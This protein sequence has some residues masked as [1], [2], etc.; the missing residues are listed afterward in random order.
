M[1]TRTLIAGA[2]G[3]ILAAGTVIAILVATSGPSYPHSWC[4]PVLAQF[5]AHESQSAFDA[6]MTGLENQGAPVGSLISD[7]DA[8]AQDESDADNDDATNGMGADLAGMNELQ[9]VGADLNQ[10]NRECGQSAS[11]SKDDNF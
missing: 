9:N 4:G 3:V 11:A 5:H 8:A 10:L 7:G 2:S 6:N 1:R